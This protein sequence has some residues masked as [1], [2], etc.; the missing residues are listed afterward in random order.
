MVTSYSVIGAAQDT[1]SE[2]F[3]LNFEAIKVIYTEWC[4]KGTNKGDVSYG[5]KVEE[6]DQS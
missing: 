1:P 2:R 6:G 4:E 3:S 5:W